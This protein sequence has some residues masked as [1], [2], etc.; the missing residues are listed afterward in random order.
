MQGAGRRACEPAAAKPAIPGV[1]L[2]HNGFVWPG[3]TVT[4]TRIYWLDVLSEIRDPRSRDLSPNPSHHC[5][6]E[7]GF[8]EPGN[9]DGARAGLRVL[10]RQVPGRQL[11]D[12]AANRRPPTEAAAL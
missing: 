8:Q 9:E 5:G 12:L 4:T 6:A 3:R 7:S 10:I 1:V 2:V 11:G